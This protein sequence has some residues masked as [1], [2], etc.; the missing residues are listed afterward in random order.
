MS[1]VIQFS[2]ATQ[3]AQSFSYDLEDGKKIDFSDQS[4]VSSALPVFKAAS[5][6]KDWSNQERA[7][8]YR[9][10]HLLE[11]AGVPVF[12]D[13]GV[14]DEGDPW[15]VFCH[16]D[17]DVFVHLCR[18]DGMYLLDSPTI[19]KSLK[20]F[21]FTD[22]I[23][24]FIS[25]SEKRKSAKVV[26]FKPGEKIFLHPSV[27]LTALIWT[28]FL[29]SD[30]LVGLA[31]DDDGEQVISHD[32]DDITSNFS[33]LLSGETQ[34]ATY[35]QLLKAAAD[36]DE[37]R[38]VTHQ[39]KAHEESFV[40]HLLQITYGT[41]ASLAALAISFKMI[42][43]KFSFTLD[44][45]LK[46]ITLTQSEN[47]TE[48]RLPQNQ[49]KT[50][51]DH[52]HSVAHE[53]ISEN[54]ELQTDGSLNDT[55][56]HLELANLV[57]NSQS[58][59]SEQT[60]TPA[61]DKNIALPSSE[62]DSGT[63]SSETEATAPTQDQPAGA[64]D[65]VNTSEEVNS[66]RRDEDADAD[67]SSSSYV[68]ESSVQSDFNIT[69]SNVA[70]LFSDSQNDLLLNSAPTIYISDE[71]MQL[72]L[73]ILENEDAKKDLSIIDSADQQ[74]SLFP[75]YDDTAKAFINFLLANRSGIDIYASNNEI[76][77]MDKSA[78]DEYDDVV[79][80]K[81][82]TLED[83]GIIST[84]GNYDDFSAYGFV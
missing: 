62:R 78:F 17:G 84:V 55:P 28:L 14:S 68:V 46:E 52:K 22:L 15:F 16:D 63:A 43:E 9:V 21:D 39:N 60:L 50:G 26:A 76:I 34:A 64:T 4:T 36:T 82:W 2:R 1:N 58:D 38:I 37:K 72:A 5:P 67:Y 70:S 75:V 3:S 61:I 25:R 18:I 30:D 57:I 27:M 44:N 69:I 33:A 13:H 51:D 8:L 24:Q 49:S 53:T 12:T 19:E 35:D 42:D 47:A 48:I 32:F 80:A 73:T 54:A 41:A 11:H 79:Y 56:V 20:G 66:I 71:P 40:G 77:V 59:I 10:Q 7:S 23:D 74:A 81:S 45:P 83:G 31:A 29:A 6:T 65:T